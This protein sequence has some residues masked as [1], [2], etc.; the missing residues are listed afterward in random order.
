MK[1]KR[2]N[3]IWVTLVVALTV[4]SPAIAQTSDGSFT[5]KGTV[6]DDNGKPID[7]AYISFNNAITAM[8]NEK[9]EFQLRNVKAGEFEYTASCIGFETAKGRFKVSTGSERLVIKL[10]EQALTLKEVTV[11]ARQSAIGSKSEIGQDAIRHIQP[12]SVSDILQLLP[13]NITTNP[14]LNSLAQANLREIGSDHNNALG[15]SVILDGSPLSNDG[16]LQALSPTRNGNSSSSNADDMRNQTTAGKGSDL[17]T[18]GVDNIASVEV[19]RGIPSVE[20]GNL[21]S[22]VV[23]VKTKAGHTPL[24]VK[25]KADPY[26]KL[27]YVGKGF[28]F[29]H[30][31][32]LNLGLDWS[33]SYSDTRRHYMGY[34]RLTL[35]LGYS[36]VFNAKGAHPITFNLRS[37][38]YSNVNNRKTDPQMSELELN[39]KNKNTGGRL[40]INGNIRMNNWLTAINYDFSAQISRTVDTHHNWI[41]TPDGVVTDNMKTGIAP[42]QFLTKAYFSDY[43]IEGV[44]INIFA[45]VK[46]NKYIQLND[47][48]YTNIKAGVDY[49]FDD[50]AG[51][52][53]T[54]NMNNPP[55][56]SSSQT[57]RPRSFSSIPALNNLSA[58]IE[59]NTRVS[60]GKTW[61]NLVA[62][63]RVSN[64]F[65]NKSKSGRSNIFVAEPRINAEYNLLD[66]HNNS[67][68]DQL[69][70]S[71]GFGISNKMPTLLYL[72]PDNAYFDNVSLS[73]IGEQSSLALIQTQAIT[74]TQN[75]NIKPTNNRKW[76]VG[77]NFKI[78][79]VKGYVNYFNESNRHEYGF[80]SVFLGMQY[81]RF[82]VPHGAADLAFDGS[83]L[84]YTLNGK[85]QTATSTI[86]TQNALWS[87]PDNTSRS[88]KHGIEY[89]LDLGVFKPLRTSLNIDGAWFHI[90]RINEK[91]YLNYISS[92]YDYV[93]MMPAGYGTISDRVNTNF[94]FITHIPAVKMIFTTTVQVVWYENTR[95]VY[96]NPDGSSKYTLS[97]DGK[98]YE[99][100]P[101]GFYS[102]NGS[103]T[104]WK[105]DYAKDNKYSLMVD[106]YKLYAF[107]SD[108]VNPWV[109]LNFRFTK[110]L[111]KICELSFTANNFLNT[112]RWHV[113]RNTLAKSQIYPD[114]YFGAEVKFKF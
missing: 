13:G 24:E 86:A 87:M 79:R 33:Q 29:S 62:G 96:E 28:N 61:L 50:N 43:K 80:S 110:E 78:G 99:V 59:D 65:L 1:P 92:T 54:F 72:Y 66:K 53:L 42:A 48:D 47:L 73:F 22:G 20:Y 46:A 49:R 2:I 11:T 16:N 58:F 97:A 108:H 40:S 95:A 51:K 91:N 45:Q 83:Q 7:V 100:Q 5:I 26:S 104:E 84:S 103:Y 30:G 19:I 63:V 3:F 85:K 64:M 75:P 88:N 111:G 69:S 27:A 105:P 34:D 109:M 76:E 38:L 39:Y 9:G 81:P 8:S 10:H 14:T 101:L 106:Q 56:S 114:N 44:P 71:G 82:N 89:S 17:R 35:S 4:F 77:V 55:K 74:N 37:S 12:K 6:T 57:L 113:N 32:A 112:S 98:T 18:I 68:F 25:F 41:A 15:T 107:N 102:N 21:T 36:N 90:K 52:G 93:P 60:I 94:R 23:I 70:I 31:G 67:L